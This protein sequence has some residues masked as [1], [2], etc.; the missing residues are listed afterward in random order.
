MHGG[1]RHVSAPK[2]IM[3]RGSGARSMPIHPKTVVMR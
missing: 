1:I 3:I 2:L